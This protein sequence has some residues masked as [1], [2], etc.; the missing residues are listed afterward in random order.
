M[1]ERVAPMVDK[2]APLIGAD[3]TDDGHLLSGEESF[4]TLPAEQSPPGSAAATPS[5]DEERPSVTAEDAK[6][7]IAALLAG[8]RPAKVSRWAQSRTKEPNRGYDPT[9]AAALART[10]GETP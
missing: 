4:K 8:V 9:R 5:D 6:A 3:C 10:E 1:S 7:R 2:S